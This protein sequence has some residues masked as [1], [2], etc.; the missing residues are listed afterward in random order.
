[1]YKVEKCW[2][3]V[4]CFQVRPP[5]LSPGLGGSWFSR[6]SFERNK[7]ERGHFHSQDGNCRHLSWLLFET[8]FPLCCRRRHSLQSRGPLSYKRPLKTKRQNCSE[9]LCVDFFSCLEAHISCLEIIFS[10]VNFSSQNQ[11]TGGRLIKV[12]CTYP[13]RRGKK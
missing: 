6:G 5:L 2:W 1:M 13:C 4:N 10:P 7:S 12:E 8:S 3:L 11:N 9:K